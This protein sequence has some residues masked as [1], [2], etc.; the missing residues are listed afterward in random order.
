MCPICIH[1]PGRAQGENEAEVGEAGKGSEEKH[2]V[3][4]VK[5]CAGEEAARKAAEEAKSKANAAKWKATRVPNSKAVPSK[6][7][8]VNKGKGQAE[9]PLADSMRVLLILHANGE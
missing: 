8:K 3:E 5:K 1:D 6:E 7:T 4:E 9:E 2:L